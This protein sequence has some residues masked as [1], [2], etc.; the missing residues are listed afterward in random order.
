MSY[1]GQ[2]M[3][4]EL[5]RSSIRRAAR[6]L[7]TEDL[8]YQILLPTNAFPVRSCCA[9]ISPAPPGRRHFDSEHSPL[10]RHD[11]DLV[12]PR[13]HLKRKSRV[14]D[15]DAADAH[16]AHAPAAHHLDVGP[17]EVGAGEL[18][19]GIGRA[20]VQ[21]FPQ[22]LAD[23]SQP[24]GVQG[25]EEGILL[26]VARDFVETQAPALAGREWLG[27]ERLPSLLLLVYPSVA[28]CLAR[29]G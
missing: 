3:R 28:S 9:T 23:V 11:L 29:T 8:K 13:D 2:E 12:L 6:E 16:S 18:R 15:D 14:L 1:V 24:E 7:V 17:V 5:L 21:V 26:S 22:D 20:G 19:R 4:L 27:L 10:L 25:L